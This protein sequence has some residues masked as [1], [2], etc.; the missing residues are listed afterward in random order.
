MVGHSLIAFNVSSLRLRPRD[1]L[2]CL[3]DSWTPSDPLKSRDV[4]EL[5]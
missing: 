4:S 1:R 3:L 5:R 2:D